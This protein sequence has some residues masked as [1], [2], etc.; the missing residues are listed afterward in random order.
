MRPCA[1]CGRTDERRMH[2]LMTLWFGRFAELPLQGGYFY[3]CPRCYQQ[4]IA[5]HLPPIL[6]QLQEDDPP[7]D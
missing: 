2:A 4:F 1:R 6:R 5:P 3:L 7:G